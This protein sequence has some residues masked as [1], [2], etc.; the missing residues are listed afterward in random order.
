MA[1]SGVEVQHREA[2]FR[3]TDGLELFEQSWFPEAP[4]GV[5]A[6]VHGYAE[7]SSRYEPV[8]VHLAG[9]GYAAHTFD[10]RGHGRSE[11]KRCFVRTFDEHLN[12]LS[13]LLESARRR[14]PDAPVFLLGHSMGGLIAALF[15]LDRSSQLSGMILSAPSV[16]LGSDFSPFKIRT[17]SFLGR[18]MPKL[19]TA[20][21]P[22]AS[23]SRDPAVVESYRTDAL[24]YQGR[25]PAR[26]ARELVSAIRRAQAEMERIDLPLLVMHGGGDLV[27][28]VEGSRQLHA[29]AGSQD[30]SL[31]IYDGFY[32]EIMNEPERERVLADVTVWLD[33][34]V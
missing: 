12:D 21:F 9:S 32:H 24:V 25:A 16:M 33:A 15:S 27:A 14:W 3:S 18:V 34:H 17:L 26:T 6:L 1:D 2:R 31:K 11:G 28:D 19:P 8:A 5:V 30:K 22:S 20:R 13:I 4:R 23:L 7:H 29:R 10:L